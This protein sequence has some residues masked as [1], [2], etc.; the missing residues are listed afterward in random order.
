MNL[1]DDYN[2]CKLC[3]RTC[4]VNRN[5]GKIGFC[6]A[7]NTVEVCRIGLHHMEEPVISGQNGSGTIFFAHCTLGC[8]FCQNHAISR[9]NSCGAEYTVQ[10]LSDAFLDL[11]QKG[12]H[13]INL[14]SPTHYMPTVLEAC[15]LARNNGLSVPIINNTGGFELQEQI[16]LQKNCID[17]YLTDYKY[18][19]PYLSK[20]YSNCADYAEYA[21]PA[22]DQM[23]K[24][25][26]EPQFTQD[27]MLKK[28]III[29]HLILPS[30][31]SDTLT[32]LRSIA[33]NWGD[34]VLVSLMRQYTPINQELPDELNRTVND[35][36]YTKAKEYFEFLGLNGFLQEKNSVGTD[37]IPD[38]TLKK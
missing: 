11:E 36:E 8:V 15:V 27:G 2:A 38:W 28:G 3:P 10:S 20:R 34:S 17:I 32:V 19:S 25:V 18:Q 14:V 9:P 37:K 30:Q 26:G 33:K 23:I 4:G 6:G 1:Y 35:E 12:A 29:R 24:N 5:Q 7:N 13:N 16:L 21:I 22:I 31:V